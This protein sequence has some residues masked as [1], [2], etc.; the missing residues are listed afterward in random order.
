M[1]MLEHSA[2]GILRHCNNLEKYYSGST[3][4][5]ATAAVLQT[6]GRWWR[7]DPTWWMAAHGMYGQVLEA[8]ELK[9]SMEG[10]QQMFGAAGCSGCTSAMHLWLPCH[11]G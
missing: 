3:P 8:K 7:P 10:R 9:H 6:L 11:K 1:V 4:Q 5:A 2:Q